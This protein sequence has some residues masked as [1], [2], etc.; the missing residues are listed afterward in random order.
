MEATEYDAEEL[1]R[2]KTSLIISAGIFTLVFSYLAILRHIRVNSAMY[3]LGLFD[4]IIYNLAHF[5]FFESS[6][7][8][9]NYLGD[10][11]SPIL[12]IFA[13]LYWIKEDV[14]LLLIVQPLLISISGYYAGMLAYHLTRERLISTAFGVAILLNS[15]VMLITQFDF[16][17]E[18]ISIPLFTYIIYQFA[19]GNSVR[20]FIASIIALTIKEDVAITVA[21]SGITFFLLSH[22][23]R[24]LLLTLMGAVYFIL[25]MKVFIPHFR[26]QTYRGDYLYLERY[27]YL[28]GSMKEVIINIL[29]NPFYPLVKMFKWSKLKVFFRLFYP[30]LFLSFLS[31]KFLIVILP[32][33]YINWIPNYPPQ[34]SLKFQYLNI[35][36]PF[37]ICSSIYGYVRLKE[38]WRS[39]RS[40]TVDFGK[41]VSCGILLFSL[42]NIII[43]Y[44]TA[45]KFKY[46]STNPYTPAFYK[47]KE[48]IPEDATLA[49]INFFGPHLTHRRYIEFAVPFTPHMY[50][51]K[52]M[53]LKMFSDAEYQLF[54]TKG[55]TT[56]D[57]EITNKRIK[58]LLESN[59]YSVI[60]NEDDVLLLKKNK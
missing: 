10:H 11:F 12:I 30:T 2:F 58:D 36:V 34:F 3:D 40:F 47:A 50:H 59:N 54:L 8:G 26:P 28:G 21:L 32:V 27:S 45:V 39:R 51:Y 55:D 19:L 53:G 4:Q 9:F 52:K 38:I 18:T 22:K 37:I 49:T 7:K 46:Y 25:V 57:P 1:K 35:V 60:F 44:N 17:P 13:P 56:S 31:P 5:R 20:V 6:I 43:F 33:L 24:Y 14:R 48:L 41:V 29:S 23:K 16:H 15:N 42:G